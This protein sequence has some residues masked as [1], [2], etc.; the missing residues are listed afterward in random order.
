MVTAVD[1]RMLERAVAALVQPATSYAL[2]GDVAA[3]TLAR[4]GAAA[5]PVAARFPLQDPPSGLRQWVLYW[6]SYFAEPP[7][8]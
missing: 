3:W 4:S 2:P 7:A 6:N 8:F 1:P 5:A